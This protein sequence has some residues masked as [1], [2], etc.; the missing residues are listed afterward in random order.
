MKSRSRHWYPILLAIM[1]PII[2]TSSKNIDWKMDGQVQW[3]KRCRFQGDHHV[4]ESLSAEEECGMV[5]MVVSRCTHFVWMNDICFLK[6]IKESD[7]KLEETSDNSTRCGS[8]LDRV[9]QKRAKN[10]T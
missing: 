10:S 1:I 4:G 3:A 7:V 8:I 5:C 9:F 6:N 2:I